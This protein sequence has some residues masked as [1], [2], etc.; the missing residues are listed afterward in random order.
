MVRQ[1]QAEASPN[2]VVLM[3]DQWPTP[4]TVNATGS[5]QRLAQGPNPGLNDSVQ[6]WQTP[7]A[8]SFRSRGGDRKDEMGLDQQ[9][10]A[11]PNQWP[12][13]KTPSGGPE[14]AQRKK[15]LGR[16]ESGGG[17]LQASAQSWATPAARDFKSAESNQTQQ[18]LY[19]SKGPP[20]SHQALSFRFS[21]PVPVIGSDGQP[22]SP[23]KRASALRPR[24][25]PAFV[26][27]LMGWPWWWTNPGQINFAAPAMALYRSRLQQH[28]YSL[29]G[30]PE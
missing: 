10:R 7:G 20:L 29:C 5:Q 30:K 9:A 12:T 13:P 8:D 27:W 25:N 4:R 26:C 18:E 22:L 2:R 17:D 21:R 11:I 1:G 24:L 3:Q 6:D 19:G 28:L 16:M 23:T 15:E 14:S